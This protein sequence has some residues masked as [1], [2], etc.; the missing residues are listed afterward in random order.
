MK[1]TT[2]KCDI[3]GENFEFNKLVPLWY[4]FNT[5]KNRNA[6]IQDRPQDAQKHICRLC[7]ED[8]HDIYAILRLA[9]AE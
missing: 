1:I 9:E 4:V 8:I 6:F 5:N 3:C 2:F 7:L